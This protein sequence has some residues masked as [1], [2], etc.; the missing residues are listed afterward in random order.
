MGDTGKFHPN[1]PQ[2]LSATAQ[3]FVVQV[4]KYQHTCTAVYHHSLKHYVFIKTLQSFILLKTV[5]KIPEATDCI[6]SIK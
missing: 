1:D 5:C 2:I 4:A 6:S 3:N